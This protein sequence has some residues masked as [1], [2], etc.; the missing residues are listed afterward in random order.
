MYT[1]V[2]P[3]PLPPGAID[4]TDTP[5]IGL[6]LG[7]ALLT[8]LVVTA[9]LPGLLAGLDAVTS[10][11]WVWPVVGTLA[12]LGAIALAAYLAGVYSNQVEQAPA[13]VFS[14]LGNGVATLFYTAAILGGVLLGWRARHA[15]RNHL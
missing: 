1:S 10:G 5:N 3:D 11:R 13:A 15:L 4:G 14:T 9:A 8:F 6:M 2:L 7:A 12:W